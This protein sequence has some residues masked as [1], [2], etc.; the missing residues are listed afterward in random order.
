MHEYDWHNLAI[1]TPNGN[2]RLTI[3]SDSTIFAYFAKA[4][5]A[6][7]APRGLAGEMYISECLQFRYLHRFSAS[8]QRLLLLGGREANNR[9]TARGCM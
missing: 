5:V 3:T 1:V 4:C 2:A 8:K 6:Y 9:E 7:E